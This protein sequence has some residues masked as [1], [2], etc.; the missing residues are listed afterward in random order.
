MKKE[1]LEEVMIVGGLVMVQFV[2]AGNSLLMSHLMS[3]GL[4]PF[5]IVIFSTFATFLILSP[6]AILFERKQ[7]PNELSARLIGKLVLI[8][9]AGVTLFQSLFLEGIRLTSPAMA[10]AMP[11][12]APGLIFFI[13]WTVRLEKMNMKCAYSKLKILGT[14]LMHSASIIQDEKDNASIFVFDRDRV[15]GCIYLL[16]AVFVLSTNVVLQASTLAEFPAPI[17]L[18][19]IT[20]LIGV[21]ITMVVQLLQ[22][23][24]GKLLTRSL[25]SI[26]NLVGFSLLGGMVS[27]A[28]VSFNGWAMKK[29]GPVMVSMFSPFATVISV[30]FSV[31][32][33]GESICLGSVGG[34]A[35][36][37]IGLYLVL[38][39]KGKEGF[40]Q[41]ES[42]ECEFDAKKPLLS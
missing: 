32:T 30:G 12:L 8:S 41:I 22:N 33:L 31:L 29:R 39:A 19:A 35:L 25:I 26:G 15:V 38:W 9:F 23:Q 18:S 34:M 24:N 14:F 21:L 11:N 36:M 16:G 6:F 3:L 37:F 27:G 20:A 4:G 2:Y 1:M 5:T 17:S 42:F 7:W 10:T 28:C 40:S 13:A